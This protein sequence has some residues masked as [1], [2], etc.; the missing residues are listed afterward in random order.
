MRKT[1]QS[2]KVCVG[3]CGVLSVSPQRCFKSVTTG[4]TVNQV[5]DCPCAGVGL[6]D[7]LEVNVSEF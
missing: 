6:K 4:Y 3:C 1:L 5:I 2:E 7:L